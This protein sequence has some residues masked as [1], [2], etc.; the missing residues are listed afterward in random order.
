MNASRSRNYSLGVCSAVALG[1]L[2]FVDAG[3]SGDWS[4]IGVIS[5]QT[6]GVLKVLS[7]A[8]V[9]V[10]GGMGILAA[11]IATSKDRNGVAWFVK[12]LLCGTISL[13]EIR[14]APRKGE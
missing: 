8:A 7:G 3:W 6:E 12:T 13:Y 4:R 5:T 1:F 10:H 2:G 14:H 9:L 11:N